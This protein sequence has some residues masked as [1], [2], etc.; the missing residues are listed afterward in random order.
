MAKNNRR[1]KR[2]TK[3]PIQEEPRVGPI[4]PVFSSN[5]EMRKFFDDFRE[6]VAPDLKILA[7]ARADGWRRLYLDGTL[8]R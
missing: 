6:Q 5:E 7:D 4:R 2:G 3:P 8:M 1:K